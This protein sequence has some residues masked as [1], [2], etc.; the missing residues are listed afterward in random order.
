MYLGSF[1]LNNKCTTEAALIE[2]SQE[3]K[4]PFADMYVMY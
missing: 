4:L 1:I 2:T 3:V